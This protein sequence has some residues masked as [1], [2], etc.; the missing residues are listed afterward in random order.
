[1]THDECT[2]KKVAKVMKEFEKGKLK[3]RDGKVITNRKQAVAIGLS[4]AEEE[5][6]ISAAEYK[7]MLDNVINYF[8]GRPKEKT[9]LSRYIEGRELIEYYYKKDKPKKCRQLEALMW[10]YVVSCMMNKI[11]LPMN[12]WDEMNKIKNIEFKRY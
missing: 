11:K 6:K 10:H 5:C 7:D 8:S 1:M 12:V 4:Q 9:I 3:Q 2:G